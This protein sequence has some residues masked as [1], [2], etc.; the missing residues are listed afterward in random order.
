MWRRVTAETPC[1]APGLKVMVYFK[2]APP[3]DV[4]VAVESM[5]RSRRTHPLKVRPTTRPRITNPDRAQ[6]S[7]RVTAETPCWAP[8]LKVSDRWAPLFQGQKSIRISSPPSRSP[9]RYAEARL[10]GSRRSPPKL[11]AEAAGRGRSDRWWSCGRTRIV[12]RRDGG[13]YRSDTRRSRRS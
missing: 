11:E 2:D 4:V 12:R 10:D 8:G 7:R 5:T 6:M 9:V 13:R 1:W 3:N